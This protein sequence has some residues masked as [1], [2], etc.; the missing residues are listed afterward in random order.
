ML[1]TKSDMA[2][3]LRELMRSRGYQLN[4]A[5]CVDPRQKQITIYRAANPLIRLPQH[6]DIAVRKVI[7][8]A[9]TICET[10]VLEIIKELIIWDAIN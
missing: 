9:K 10:D 3:E 2:T 4:V 1:L 8:A 7:V 6:K 5:M